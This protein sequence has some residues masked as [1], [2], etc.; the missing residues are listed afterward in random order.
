MLNIVL[1]SNDNHAINELARLLENKRGK[2]ETEGDIWDKLH[3][4]LKL[5]IKSVVDN[6]IREKYPEIAERIDDSIENYVM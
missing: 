1:E 3:D 2:V 6:K 4:S 5:L